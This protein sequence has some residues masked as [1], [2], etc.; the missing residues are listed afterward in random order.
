MVGAVREV[1][2]EV[3]LVPSVAPLRDARENTMYV[4]GIRLRN[5]NRVLKNSFVMIRRQQRQVGEI[6][7]RNVLLSSNAK[8][9]A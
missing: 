8:S 4:S 3:R 7:L 9:R 1:P 5:V 6:P 2:V